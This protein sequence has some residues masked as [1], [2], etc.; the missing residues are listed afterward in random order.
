M[1]RHRYASSEVQLDFRWSAADG[2][3]Q[4]LQEPALSV[5]DP[6]IGAAA[7]ASLFARRHSW[8]FDL[9]LEQLNSCIKV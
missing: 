1:P 4:P 9:Q 3:K 5:I 6:A 2:E 7:P 8:L